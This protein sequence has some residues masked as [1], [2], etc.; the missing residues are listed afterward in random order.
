MIVEPRRFYLLLQSDQEGH[1]RKE[2]RVAVQPEAYNHAEFL[3]VHI[4]ERDW[5][6]VSCEHTWKTIGDSKRMFR[7]ENDGFVGMVVRALSRDEVVGESTASLM[8][9]VFWRLVIE[10]DDGVQYLGKYA[11]EAERFYL[12][13]RIDGLGARSEAAQAIVE[14]ARE[15]KHLYLSTAARWK[16]LRCCERAIDDEE[17]GDAIDSLRE[18]AGADDNNIAILRF[19]GLYPQYTVIS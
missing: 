7:V 16:V 12:G 19:C 18:M 14:A 3:A 11:P 4:E 10:T 8:H 15:V 5:D 13:C 9:A 1:S 2:R 6:S 17:F